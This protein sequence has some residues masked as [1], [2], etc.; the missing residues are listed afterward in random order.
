MA[1]FLAH[2]RW[3]DANGWQAGHILSTLSCR[4]RQE[5]KRSRLLTAAPHSDR[6]M[7]GAVVQ[8]T[9]R[10][11]RQSCTGITAE[12]DT[13]EYDVL[14]VFRREF[15]WNGRFWGSADAPL[16]P[17]NPSLPAAPAAGQQPWTTHKPWP[18]PAPPQGAPH[19]GDPNNRTAR[20][21]PPPEQADEYAAACLLGSPARGPQAGRVRCGSVMGAA[22]RQARLD[23]V[24]RRDR[25]SIQRS[26]VQQRHL[27]AA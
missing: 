27:A 26:D 4:P 12:L 18:S 11:A 3:A 9:P 24:R 8:A 13:L 6:R 1:T 2:S 5:P 20:P 25:G 21:A 19:P 7:A 16:P 14:P 23:A 15:S 10:P 22:R 17:A